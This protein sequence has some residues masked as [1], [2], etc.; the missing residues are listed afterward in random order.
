MAQGPRQSSSKPG[1]LSPA[2]GFPPCWRGGWGCCQLGSHPGPGTG[3][4]W[5]A[6]SISQGPT[7]PSR[8]FSEARSPTV[9]FVCEKNKETRSSVLNVQC[10]GHFLKG[11]RC[12]FLLRM[13]I[14]AL[15]RAHTHTPTSRCMWTHI[16]GPTLVHSALKHGHAVPAPSTQPLP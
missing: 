14:S 16:P 11:S 15:T 4:V 6:H 7:Q 8:G 3:R 9:S 10:P 2:L 13:R 12:S 1:F 5:I